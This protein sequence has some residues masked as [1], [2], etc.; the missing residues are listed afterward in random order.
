MA[1][2][3]KVTQL[4]GIKISDV[5]RAPRIMEVDA[6]SSSSWAMS[7]VIGQSVELDLAMLAQG[8]IN[9]RNVAWD[10]FELATLLVPEAAVYNLRA[11]AEKLGV[12]V[13]DERAHRAVA[14]AELT[15][16]VFLALRE[17][18]E[19]IPLEVL[20]RSA[21]RPN[22]ANG[23]S[24]TCSGRWSTRSHER[25]LLVGNVNQVAVASKG[26]SDAVLDV[27]LLRPLDDEMEHDA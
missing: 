13:D 3:Y 18:I 17:R 16:R 4:T 2:P 11:I 5:A 6:N 10:T 14:D 9:L 15:M 12:T 25:V 26:I 8:G 22:E 20:A 24:G 23:R 19:E 7:P 1:V 27:G 21:R